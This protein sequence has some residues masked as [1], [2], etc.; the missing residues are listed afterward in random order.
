M[1]TEYRADVTR[2]CVMYYWRFV[3]FVQL[4]TPLSCLILLERYCTFTLAFIVM[5]CAAFLEQ[6]NVYSKHHGLRFQKHQSNV[7]CD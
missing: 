3:C 5:H 6:T 1:I 7:V 2:V 4:H